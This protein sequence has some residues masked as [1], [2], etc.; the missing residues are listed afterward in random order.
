MLL[1]GGA[2]L[3]SSFYFGEG[4]S[5]NK[6]KNEENQLKACASASTYVAGSSLGCLS[7][8]LKKRAINVPKEPAKCVKIL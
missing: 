8:H 5:N 6:S 2:E 3:R 7:L 1:S 4:K